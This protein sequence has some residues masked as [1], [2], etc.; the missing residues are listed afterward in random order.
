MVIANVYRAFAI[1]NPHAYDIMFSRSIPGFR[2]STDAVNLS[3][4]ALSR[5]VERV[6]NAQDNGLIST[7]P[8]SD[9]VMITA[10]LWATLHGMISLEL[11]GLGDEIINWRSVFENGIIFAVRGLHPTVHTTKAL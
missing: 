6:Q 10:W 11:E 9:P 7:E 5:M 2:P 4:E 1:N 8:N 3:L